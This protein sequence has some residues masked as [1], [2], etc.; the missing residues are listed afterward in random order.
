[1]DP[2]TQLLFLKQHR[3]YVTLKYSPFATQ[4]EQE[5]SDL[6]DWTNELLEACFKRVSVSLSTL[7]S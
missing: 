5:L 2:L 4:L 3:T 6:V 1:M 7:S